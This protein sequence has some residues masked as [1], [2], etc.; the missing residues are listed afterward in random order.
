LKNFIDD[1]ARV[2]VEERAHRKYTQQRVILYERNLSGSSPGINAGI[3]V[4]LR[5]RGSVMAPNVVSAT[6]RFDLLI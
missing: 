5:P 2:K 3:A 1:C 4:D 6:S